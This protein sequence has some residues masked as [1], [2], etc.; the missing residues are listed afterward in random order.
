[1]RLESGTWAEPATQLA[2]A[3]WHTTPDRAYQVVESL[4]QT[5]RPDILRAFVRQIRPGW[6]D[7]WLARRIAEVTHH[8]PSR[9]A[10][11]VN[12]YE[13]DIAHDFVLRAYCLLNSPGP[14]VD[15]P[16]ATGEGEYEGLY[17]EIRSQLIELFVF[18]PEVSDA[19]LEDELDLRT[20]R[21]PFFIT[22]PGRLP[23]PRVVQRL[24]HDSPFRQATFF[25]VTDGPVDPELQ[26]KY[27]DL[28]FVDLPMDRREI[29][30]IINSYVV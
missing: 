4:L 5:P 26:K 14:I 16:R 1:M 12:C 30:R 11:S 6:I 24:L 13:T 3:L 19:A 15:A 28:V 27:K 18:E 7:P 25:F 8:E 23:R 9:R 17:R 22:I 21:K 29:R 10:V 2:W 20:E